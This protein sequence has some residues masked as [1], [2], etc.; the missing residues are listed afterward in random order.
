MAGLNCGIPSIVAWPILKDSVNL[1]LAIP[2]IFAEEAMKKYAFPEN[3]DDK[4]VSGESGASG[5]AAVIAL[6][7]SDKLE[8]VRSKLGIG[9]NS[10][11]L[12]VNTE[13]S[14]DPVNYDKIVN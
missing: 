14:T 4:I 5:L 12:L 9:E 3:G 7:T 2:D 1:F 8:N 13:G 11:V 6:M 10:K